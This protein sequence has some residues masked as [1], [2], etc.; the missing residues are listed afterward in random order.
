[1]E[2][3]TLDILNAVIYSVKYSDEE[4]YNKIKKRIFLSM[5]VG[6]RVDEGLLFKIFI[7]SLLK[8]IGNIGVKEE[9]DK[10]ISTYRSAEIVREMPEIIPFQYQIADIILETGERLDGSGYP[11]GKRK[12][13]KEAQIIGMVEDYINA[14][15]EFCINCKRYNPENL[16]LL[17]KILEEK[18]VKKILSSEDALENYIKGKLKKYN[19]FKEELNGV[20]EEQFLTMIAS[21][22]DT[23]HKYTAG[24]T[25]RVASYSYRIAKEMEYDK[26]RLSKIRYASYLHDIGKLAIDINILDKD[27]KL[28][29]E[30]FEI[31]KSHAKYSFYILWHLPSLR[32]LSFGALHHE[33]LDGTGYPMGFKKDRIPEEAQIIE[34]AD[35]LDALTSNRSYRNPSTFEDAFKIL[36]NMIGKSFEKY[37]YDKAKICFL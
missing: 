23:K 4:K 17:E 33:K 31:V 27:E 7:S 1:M 32:G 2:L 12:I 8:G 24:H 13:K 28:T 29:D 37:I 36:E 5:E 18:S 6:K 14:K 10:Q 25:R 3:L 19:V 15:K 20:E 26:K 9:L 30:E 34:L 35:I 22:I 11:S 21:M 16:K